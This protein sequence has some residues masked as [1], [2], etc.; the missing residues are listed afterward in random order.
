MNYALTPAELLERNLVL[1]PGQT[2]TV[3]GLVFTKGKHQGEPN[4]RLVHNLV[5]TGRLT[6]VDPT[7]P[8][9]R[10]TFSVEAVRRYV[11]GPVPA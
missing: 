8:F 10:W 6:P 3:L 9:H 1:T 5:N 2:A 4:R 7:Q 11:S